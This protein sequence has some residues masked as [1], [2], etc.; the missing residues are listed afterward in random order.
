M[1]TNEMKQ[2]RIEQNALKNRICKN[3]VWS[4]NDGELV[5]SGC[6][7]QRLGGSS[8]CAQCRDNFRKS[9]MSPDDI[10]INE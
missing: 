4:F 3:A 2:K 1:E 7:N 10:I 5:N 8:R 9:S 6:N